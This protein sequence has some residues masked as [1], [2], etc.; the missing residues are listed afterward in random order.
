[1]MMA[2]IFFTERLPGTSI[3]QTAGLFS[4][5]A[6]AALRS[7]GH[8]HSL[9]KEHD[10]PERLPQKQGLCQVVRGRDFETLSDF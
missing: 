2:S 4:V 5:V 3:F 7:F 10:T 9:A 8:T 6:R 1:L